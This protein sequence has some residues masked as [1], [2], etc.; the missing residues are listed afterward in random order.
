MKEIIITNEEQ[1]LIKVVEKASGIFYEQ[2]KSN[3]REAE[4]V[5]AR[6]ILGCLLRK[7]TS[8]TVKRAGLVVNRDH[9]SI[10]AYER[11]HEKN[12]KFYPAYKRVYEKALMIN[13]NN[14]FRTTVEMDLIQQQIIQIETS[15]KRIKKNIKC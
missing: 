14:N 4:I 8:C 3:S 9:S 1:T 12:L 13:G 6:N 15:L 11:E 7:E 10:V 5:I 2:I